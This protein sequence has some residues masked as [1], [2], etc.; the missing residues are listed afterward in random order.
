MTPREMPS[1][2]GSVS[3]RITSDE[4][5]WSGDAWRR[6]ACIRPRPS[7]GNETSTDQGPGPQSRQFWGFDIAASI[8]CP[9][10]R[11]SKCR[12]V[13][14]PDRRF[15]F[16]LSQSQ[17]VTLRGFEPGCPIGHPLPA[18]NRGTVAFPHELLGDMGHYPGKVGSCRHCRRRG[19]TA[20]R[21]S[22]LNRSKRR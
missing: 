19:R 3:Y 11:E 20:K 14:R 13:K 17:P 2:I 10:Y 1:P 4:E 16:A 6:K 18:F 8:C 5:L 22:E 9:K 15:V 12:P 7:D 21:C